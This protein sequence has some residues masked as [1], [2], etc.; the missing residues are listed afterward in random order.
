M[1]RIGYHCSHEQF[2]PRELLDLVVQAERAGFHC[3]SA[4]DHFHPW[5]A[6]QGQSG[7]VWS[8]LGAAMERT[9]L[10]FR[11]VSAPGYR[12]HPAI[13][14][15]A[16]ATLSTMYPDRLWMALG[17]GQRLNE[18][19]TGMAWPQK[20]ERQAL[21]VECVEVMRALWAGEAVEWTF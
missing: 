15:Q 21:L 9:Q 8:W 4:S 20:Q 12:Y 13:L 11:T 19:I 3:A 10:P 18:A 6:Q 14:A 7:F 17:T 1:K 16:G 2:G 5:S